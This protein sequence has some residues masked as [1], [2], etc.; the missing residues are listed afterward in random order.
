[1]QHD[2][3]RSLARQPEDVVCEARA[4]RR[5]LDP[6][7]ELSPRDVEQLE[8]HRQRGERRLGVITRQDRDGQEPL[9]RRTLA[10]RHDLE[11]PTVLRAHAELEAA[12]HAAARGAQ[13]DLERLGRI[14]RDRQRDEGAT[15][16][17]GAR[18]DRL[19]RRIERG[20]ELDLGVRR[21][22]ER[23]HAEHLV[24]RDEPAQLLPAH[25]LERALELEVEAT[26]G[27]GGACRGSLREREARQERAAHEGQHGEEASRAGEEAASEGE[28]VV[29]HGADEPVSEGVVAVGHRIP[30]A[31]AG[32]GS[33]GLGG[34]GGRGGGEPSCSGASGS[35]P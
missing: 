10:Q 17:I 19:G 33:K 22:P 15:V 1:M 21:E 16:G 6:R 25:A 2:R 35:S 18:D 29:T 4:V 8:A 34:S 24:G 3:A 32:M 14:G 13:H 27:A 5:H 23:A 26:H 30:S 28:R 31:S 20:R 7:Q 12:L 11:L 9:G